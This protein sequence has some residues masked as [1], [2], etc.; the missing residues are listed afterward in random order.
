MN[1]K[2]L[3]GLRQL[4]ARVRVN[5]KYMNS[6]RA[7]SSIMSYNYYKLTPSL[8][9]PVKFPGSVMHGRACKEYIF[10]SYNIFFQ[11]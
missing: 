8:P 9:Q 6:T 1:N 10:R 11:C 7:M 2:D 4:S 5:A 3:S